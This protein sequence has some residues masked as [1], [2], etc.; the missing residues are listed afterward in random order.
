MKVSRSSLAAKIRA[1][2]SKTVENGATEAEA[3]SAA[4]KA[5]QLMDDHQ[6]S[7]SETELREEG[8]ARMRTM[9]PG[10]IERLIADRLCRPISA[11]TE[12]KFWST[13]GRTVIEAMGL[14]S[15]IIFAEWL[16][17]TLVAIVFRDAQA[18]AR[19]RR[20]RSLRLSFAYG[21]VERI[22]E[23]MMQEVRNRKAQQTGTGTGLVVAKGAMIAAE[24][25][26]LG[27]HLQNRDGQ[28]ELLDNTARHQGALAGDK[29]RWD[30]PIEKETQ[31]LLAPK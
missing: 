1:L 30:K 8:V 20:D 28:F 4:R 10:R 31:T 11:Y 17:P 26:A 16:L 24:M 9:F 19:Q 12:T 7:L 6:L 13:S 3:A 27:L 25:K 15:D 5:R 2:L 21:A 14:K 29:V 23:R 18:Y 22:A